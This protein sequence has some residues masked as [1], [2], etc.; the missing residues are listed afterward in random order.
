MVGFDAQYA[1]PVGTGIALELHAVFEYI[2]QIPFRT[3]QGIAVHAVV[4]DH[5]IARTAFADAGLKHR[6]IAAFHL[7]AAC[8]GGGAVGAALGNA[9]HAVVLRLG[10]NSVRPSQIILLLAGDDGGRHAR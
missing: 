9:M 1:A 7:A 5:H 2:L 8:A 4:A 3:H 10:Y 6:Q